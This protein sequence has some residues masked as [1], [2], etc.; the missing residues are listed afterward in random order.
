MFTNRTPRQILFKNSFWL[1][2]ADGLSRLIKFAVTLYVIRALGGV[3]YGR[4]A[5]AF[6]FVSL[7]ANLFDFGVS[8]IVTREFAKSR[9]EEGAFA[10]LLALKLFLGVLTACLI[11]TSGVFATLD[12]S[13]RLMIVV[14]ACSFWLSEY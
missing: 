10:P 7:F 12:G 11:G 5:F 13:V 2:V 1:A 8:L 9:E 14:L 3:E 6:A 4:F